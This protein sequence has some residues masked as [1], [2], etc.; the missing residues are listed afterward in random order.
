MTIARSAHKKGIFLYMIK[1]ITLLNRKAGLSREEFIKRWVDE[2]TILSTKLGMKGYRSNVALE[3][4]P[5]DVELRYD[6]SAEIW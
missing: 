1:M 2:H 4:Q 3:P 5:G 6:G